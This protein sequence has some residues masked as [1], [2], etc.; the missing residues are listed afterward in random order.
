MYPLL[1][2][3][4]ESERYSPAE[5]QTI[6]RAFEVAKTAHGTQKRMSGEEYISHPVAVAYFLFGLGL[7]APTVSAALLHDTLEDTKLT[8][9]ELLKEFGKEIT[10]LVDGVTKLSAIQYTRSPGLGP[11]TGLRAGTNRDPKVDSLKKMFFAMAEDI[12]VII[13][14]LADRYH[15]METLTYMDPDSRRRIA[16]ETLEIYAPIAGRLGMG[17]LKGQLEDLCF[18]Y[19]YPEE[20]RTL[21]KQVKSKFEDRI[22]YIDRTRPVIRRLLENAGVKILDIHSRAKRYYSLFQKLHRYDMDTD[23]VF[24][25]VAMRVL[26]PDV[27]S[28]YEAMG[29]IH[30]NYLPMPGLIKDYIALPKPNGYRSLHTT[31]FSEKGRV[32]E[33][34]IR[35]PEMHEH[36]ENGIAAHWAY[37][38]SGKRKAIKAEQAEIQWVSQL[39]DFLKDIKTS[40]GLK[41]IKIDFFKNR[42]FV[43]TPKGDVK[44]LPDGATPIDFAYAI[45]TE[46]GHSISGARVNEKMVPLDCGLKNGDVVDIIKHKNGKPSL[47]WLK[48]VKTAQAKKL[49][50]TWFKNNDPT[51]ALA[52]G[53][54]LL[55]KELAPVASSYEKL[56][57]QDINKILATFTSKSMDAIL[58][59]ISMGDLNPADIVKN[60]FP[61][62]RKAALDRQT[63]ARTVKSARQKTAPANAGNGLYIE[64]QQG[65][66]YKLGKCCSPVKGQ[67]VC[68]YITRAKGVTVHLLSCKNLKSAQEERILDARWG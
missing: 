53:K 15:N 60:V 20:Y 41:N 27:R 29:V 62:E 14:K 7:D 47:D 61:E 44:D 9:E 39:K 34:Q 42:I 50:K 59:R 32:V 66:L 8:K 56:S 48:L 12:R 21:V 19:V 35:T 11:S 51:I 45:H 3:I 31:I 49:I 43:F 22:K 33:V 68:G 52:N 55:N 24:D 46:L 54:A 16:M 57:R 1:Q 36:A 63:T 26:V 30:A 5:K 67:D 10:F 40:E 37:S 65:L 6:Q 38:E 58:T 4:L 28:C 25:L 17:S 64:G 23:K 13:I 18:P 2:K